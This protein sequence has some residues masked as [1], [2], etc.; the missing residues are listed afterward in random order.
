MI[1]FVKCSRH[2]FNPVLIAVNS[3]SLV[4]ICNP[5]ELVKFSFWLISYRQLSCT[6]CELFTV[7]G[8]GFSRQTNSKKTTP[9]SDD[10]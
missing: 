6:H 7:Y 4:V 9:N 2:N 8:Q 1:I 5:L 10:F 3:S